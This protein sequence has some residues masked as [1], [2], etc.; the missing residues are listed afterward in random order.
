MTFSGVYAGR[1]VL[2]TGHTGFKGSWL[3]QWLLFLGA[4]V[5]GY[6]LDIPSNPSMFE[7]LNIRRKIY[8]IKGDVRDKQALMRVMKKFKPEIVFHLAAQAMVRRSYKDPTFTFETNVLGTMN[9]LECIRFCPSVQVG[10]II[11]SDKCYR[12]VEWLWG[13]R[14]N[15]TLGGSDPYSASKACAELISYAY[16]CS[17]YADNGIP[18]IATTRAGNVIGGGDWAVDRIVPDCIQA[19]SKK[20]GVR[21]RNPKATR[22]WQ[23]VLEP[24]SG[25]LWLGVRLLEKDSSLAGEAF[26]FGPNSANN[27]SVEELINS[28]AK[29][30]PGVGWKDI[31]QKTRKPRESTLLKLNCEKAFSLLG[32]RSVLSFQ[33]TIQMTAEWY[34]VYYEQQEK[35]SIYDLTMRQVDK[36]VALAKEKGL[37]WAMS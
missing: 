2:V 32:W 26:N 25:Y 19:W 16:N 8:D 33:E 18:K 28:M 4:K 11:T 21:I 20:R 23:H 29:Y 14:E 3:C 34:K 24:L 5:A 13:Y 22:P 7:I 35:K 1:K 37:P 30:W 9:V 17:Y 27:P 31:S 15:D 6:S 10:V 12:N 36:Y